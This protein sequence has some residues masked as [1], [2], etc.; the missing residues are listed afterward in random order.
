MD[1]LSITRGNH[2][3]KV[4]GNFRRNDLSDHTASEVA[5]YPA[6][7][8]TLAG[9][10]TDQVAS[11]TNYNFAIS[12]VQPIAFY[13]LGLYAQ[14][15]YRATSKLKLTMTLRA[16]R[17]SPGVCQHH[18][19]GLPVVA[20]PNL[21]KGAGVP[22]NQSYRT[23]LR[24][25]LPGLEAV[26]FEPRFGVAWTPWGSKT[27]FRG[28]VGLFSDLYPG[29]LLSPIDTNFPQVN[30]WNVPGGSLAWD[31]K[32]PSSTAFPGSGVALVQQ[33][34]SAFTS[35]YNSGGSLTTYLATPGLP[36]ACATTP[37]ITDVTRN[38]KNPKYL[39]W[40]FEVQRT[41][42]RT[43]VSVNYVGNHG[44][45]EI[46][47]NGYL[48]AFGFGSLP[49]TAPDPRVGRV[50]FTNS[51]AIS[52]YHGVTA[53]IQ[54]NLWHGLTGRFNYTYSHALDEVS[55]GGV[56]PF[57]VFYSIVNQIDPFK[58]RK[59]YASADYDVRHQLSASYIYELPFKS[60]HHALNAAIGG[61]QVS[62]TLFWRQ[63]F[64]FSAYD[65]GT[66]GGLAGNN[67]SSAS[68]TILLQPL[69]SKRNFSNVGNCV[70]SACFGIVAGG[71]G[72]LLYPNG[73]NPTAPYLFS[74]PTDFTGNVVGRNAFR[75][76]GF[77]GGDMSARK[78]FH[79]R[80]RMGFELGLDAYNWFNHANYGTPYPST[81][82]GGLFGQVI[83][84]QTPPTSPYGAFASA[85][86]DMRI[87]QL[88]GKFTF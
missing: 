7:N 19:A 56:N 9:F 29:V 64:P 55:N 41:F 38:L 31:L 60:A 24:T 87:A 63:G 20:F 80:E 66:I 86:T 10:A 68:S 67:L 83:F 72:S 88:T 76:P 12:P 3:I 79:I 57:S 32:S 16:D 53:Y 36:A 11:F 47:T 61:W 52:N 5:T 27:V 46:Y 17:N 44:Y 21:T 50:N 65:G 30:I 84:T 18:C 49:A 28:G 14:D 33:C 35:N 71:P 69:F 43:L 37:A 4:G 39:E 82:F 58:L 8:T 78:K 15:E 6:V 48:N 2:S 54:E 75:G 23:D 26:V 74:I 34:N 81:N 25:I 73:L 13:S 45:D 77:L 85:A 1:D 40:N 42:G 70:T 59:N 62:G 22:Y 51:G